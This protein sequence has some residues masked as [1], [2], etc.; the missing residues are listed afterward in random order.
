MQW[1]RAQPIG[2]SVN[3][4]SYIFWVTDINDDL[5]LEYVRNYNVKKFP[6]VA[7]I[8]PQTGE[9]LRVVIDGA[10]VPLKAVIEKLHDHAEIYLNKKCSNDLKRSRD[11][12][13][14]GYPPVK[15]KHKNLKVLSKVVSTGTCKDATCTSLSAKG[16]ISK[17]PI[18]MEK[19]KIEG[20]NVVEREVYSERCLSK[21]SIG[22]TFGPVSVALKFPDGR[23]ILMQ[24]KLDSKL[25]VVYNYTR[26]IL[27]S[28]EF[29]LR[30][31]HPSRLI[32]EDLNA[33]VESLNIE[34]SS[35]MVKYIHE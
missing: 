24:C 21:K 6:H 18:E 2:G 34:G 23:R 27:G 31:T 30:T 10:M 15:Y 28:T 22:N 32:S 29:E 14:S 35:I 19:K 11:S 5:G 12:R 9:Q 26:S 25:S 13:E 33:T 3:S 17:K 7:L 16:S 1:P 8:D 4:C 20:I